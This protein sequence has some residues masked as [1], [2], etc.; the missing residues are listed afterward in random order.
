MHDGQQPG[1]NVILPVWD[2]VLSNL[3]NHG[4]SLSSDPR[5]K[6][7]IRPGSGC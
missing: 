5:W 4:R 2:H 7:G 3:S 1:G 6:A